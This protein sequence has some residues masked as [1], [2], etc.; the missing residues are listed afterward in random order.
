MVLTQSTPG[1][2]I[3]MYI[4]THVFR[5]A[6]DSRFVAGHNRD[7]H[8]RTIKESKNIIRLFV[9]PSDT[10]LLIIHSRR[11][12]I[13]NLDSIFDVRNYSTRIHG[14]GIPIRR[15]QSTYPK[16]QRIASESHSVHGSP[17]WTDQGPFEADSTEPSVWFVLYDLTS[18]L[19]AEQYCLLPT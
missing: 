7:L 18:T 8:P 6:I 5:I 15:P 1:I 9:S 19:V 2:Y 17:C 12:T 13:N 4:C 11:L 16:P 10:L 3:Y 14:H